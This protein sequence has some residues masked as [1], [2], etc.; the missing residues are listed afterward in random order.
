MDWKYAVSYPPIND[1]KGERTRT[2]SRLTAIRRA[3]EW[4][5]EI[6]RPVSVLELHGWAAFS[7]TVANGV[8]ELRGRYTDRDRQLATAELMTLRQIEEAPAHG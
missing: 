4:S 8:A 3:V 7:V 6:G 1:R 5:R 2:K